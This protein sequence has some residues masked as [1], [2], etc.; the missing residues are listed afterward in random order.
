MVGPVSLEKEQFERENFT[1]DL[2][3]SP[4]GLNMSDAFP[5]ADWQPWFLKV[6]ADRIDPIFSEE[7]EYS[8]EIDNMTQSSS[9]KV[10]INTLFPI[11]N[12]SVILPKLDFI[13]P[14]RQ[15]IDASSPEWIEF[16]PARTQ[17][18][19][20]FFADY[21]SLPNTQIEIRSYLLGSNIWAE[22]QTPGTVNTGIDG[23]G[24]EYQDGFVWTGTG[25]LHGWYQAEGLF[26]STKCVYP[27]L[28]HARWKEIVAAAEPRS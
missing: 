26:G 7:P 17:Q 10:F 15:E 9:P 11:G 5:I 19:T 12:E 22:P 1:V 23:G 24:N 8:V 2:I 25:E 20:L 13:P 21:S 16:L 27:N 18:T 28:S 3:Q 14:Y 4:H 6:S